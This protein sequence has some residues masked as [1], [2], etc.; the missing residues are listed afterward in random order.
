VHHKSVAPVPARALSVAY[1]IGKDGRVIASPKPLRDA[2]EKPLTKHLAD[3]LA[4]LKARGRCKSHVAHTRQRLPRLLKECNWHLLRDVCADGFSKWRVGQE[5]LSAKTCNEYLG[6]AKAFF[7]WLDRQ[8]RITH[9]PLRTVG[10]A[11]TRGKETFKRR[12]LFWEELLRLIEGSGKRGVVYA[13][14]ALTGL[15]NVAAKEGPPN[16]LAP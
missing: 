7:N 8:G 12:A 2:A 15:H 16:Q 3:F 4:D 13:L 6:H 1:K 11:E 9:N 14:A 5:G 10:K